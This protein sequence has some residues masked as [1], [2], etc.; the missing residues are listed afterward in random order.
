[1]VCRSEIFGTANAGWW[2]SG[3]DFTCFAL[4]L[5]LN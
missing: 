3:S 4:L 1:V 2:A 5:R